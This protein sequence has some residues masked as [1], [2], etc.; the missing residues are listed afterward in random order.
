MSTVREN[1]VDPIPPRYWWL[2]RIGVASA[3]L[4]VL[5]A[6]VRI[7]WGF[8][9]DRRM[10]AGVARCR[11]AGGPVTFEDF[12]ALSSEI[13]DEDNAAKLYEQAIKNVV[14]TAA[15][16]AGLMDFLDG[17]RSFAA[18]ADA[19]RELYN[20]N[21]AALELVR[22]ARERQE[23]GWSFTVPDLI[24]E[25]ILPYS[26]QRGL[27][28]LLAYAAAFEFTK[29]ELLRAIDMT[30][31]SL[32][33]SEAISESPLTTSLLVSDVCTGLT[34][35]VV[36][37][38]AHRLRIDEDDQREPLRQRAKLLIGE[39]LD[40]RRFQQSFARAHMGERANL[41]FLWETAK[42]SSYYQPAISASTVGGPAAWMV[43]PAV[44]M[45]AGRAIDWESQLAELAMAQRFPQ[46]QEAVMSLHTGTSSLHLVTC[47]VTG[48]Y[49]NSSLIFKFVFR[50]I[51]YRR[52]A[53]IALAIRLF[54]MDHGSLPDTLD[55]LVPDYLASVPEDPFAESPGPLIY[56]PDRAEPVL[57]S[58]GENGIDDGGD[59]PFKGRD[60]SPRCDIVF[61]LNGN[62]DG[63]ARREAASSKAVKN[64]AAPEHNNEH[65]AKNQEP[66]Q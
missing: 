61:F 39:L 30:R 2:K 17:D 3:A 50:T 15:N 51:A 47:P 54:E 34:C 20:K 58:V 10:R 37:D 7:W 41:I 43:N 56:R 21:A 27:A 24:A 42:L 65:S 26:S 66:E 28:K 46:T 19:A 53:A 62:P 22:R 33:Y 6:A 40:V 44:V 25:R 1:N 31:D 55:E 9:A 60:C 11:A 12:D 18:D 45:D 16:G 52:M 8:E 5:L 29:G 49:E 13:N 4:I 57:Y 59:Y 36:E 64:N 35:E 14:V 38:Y 32:R 23:I 48:T 63:P